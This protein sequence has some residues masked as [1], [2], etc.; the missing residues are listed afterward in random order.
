[1]DA[2][3]AVQARMGSS[4]LPGKAML[5]LDGTPALVHEINRAVSVDGIDHEDVVVATSETP[6]DNI[7]AITAKDAGATVYRG[8]EANVIGRIANAVEEVDADIAVR[9]CGDN[10]LIDPRLPETLLDM[11]RKDGIEYASSKFEHTFP[12]GHNVDGFTRGT[13]TRAAQDADSDHHREHVAQYFKAYQDEVTAVNVTAE[14]VFGSE[15]VESIPAFRKLRLTLDE[16]DDYRLLSRVYEEV[17][18]DQIVETKKAIR[19]IVDNNL[20][21]INADVEQQVW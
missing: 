12:I 3:V 21:R 18:Y 5:P 14:E 15:F 1:M 19:Y 11:V 13:I 6:R 2:I 9:L 16:A 20:H 17:S 8:S 10:T 4:R 7:I